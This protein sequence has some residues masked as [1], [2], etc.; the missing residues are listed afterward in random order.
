MVGL[1]IS[2]ALWW[3]AKQPNAEKNVQSP[4]VRDV[5]LFVVVRMRQT[6][7]VPFR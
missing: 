2:G 7:Q 6:K 3:I 1:Q 5:L 4:L